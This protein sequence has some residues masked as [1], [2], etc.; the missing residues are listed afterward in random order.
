MTERERL[1]NE[2]CMV[3]DDED[4]RN[5]LYIILNKYEIIQ[6][7]TSIALLQE[8][9]NEFLIRSFIVA[10][11]VKGCTERT[12]H[13]YKDRV[14]A[15]IEKM[16]K[17]V[18]DITTEDIR[19]YI[20]KRLYCDGVSK[21]TVGNEIRCL[22]SFFTY[23]STE[24]LIKKNPMSRVDTIKK[25]KTRKEAFTEIELEKMRLELKTNREKAIYEILLCTGC[26]V[27]EIVNIKL[28][29]IQGN[30]ILIH[31]K[32]QKDRI[33]YLNA[34]GQFILDQYM[35]ERTDNNPYLFAGGI[36][37]QIY[38]RLSRKR[39]DL[40]EWYKYP[41]LVHESNPADKG[42]IESFIR[43]LGRK[44]GV[45]AYPHKFRRTC[46]T[47]ALRRGMPI[48]QVSKMLGHESIETTQIYLDLSEQDLKEAHRKYVL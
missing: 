26:R 48:E 10:K 4:I 25:E 8:D 9:R 36:F 15:S 16:G 42:S 24:E 13:Y 19:L 22:K 5:R 12:L 32:G 21:T 34:K 43:K 33:V 39:Q 44:V 17:T 3:I 38:N 29:E 37:M 6:R 41:E 11:T 40:K 45:R 1:Y 18:D 31:G 7:E 20:A 46:A 47:F 30:E 14:S 27:S 23:V 35:N 2:L 28:S